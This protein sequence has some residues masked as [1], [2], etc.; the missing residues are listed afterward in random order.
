LDV[1]SPQPVLD[2]IVGSIIGKFGQIDVLVNN[3]G[4]VASGVWEEMSHEET[5]AQFNTNFFGA[6]NLTRAVLPTMRAQKSGTLVF[7]SSIAAWHGVGAGGPYSSSKFALEGAVECLEKETS[8]LGIETFL[9][10]LGQF[11]TDILN[12]ARK[13]NKKDNPI[14]DYDRVSAEL[15]DRHQETTGK[16]PGDPKLA[17]ERIL[18]V[19]RREGQLKGFTK[20]PLRIP[21]GSDAVQVMQA[22]CEETMGILKQPMP[23]IWK[24]IILTLLTTTL[25]INKFVTM[26][27]TVP[28]DKQEIIT[29]LFINN[30]YVD[31]QNPKKISVY[32]PTTEELV[33]DQIPV[34]G[35]RDVDAAVAAGNAA[36]VKWRA[37]PG[38]KRR[39]LLL[40]FADLLE[41]DQEELGFL[42]RLTLGAPYLAFGQGEIQT[43][44]ENF[45]YFAGWIDKFAGESFPQDDGFYK[46]VRNE[47]LGVVAGIIPWNGPLASVGLKA[48]PA[49]ATGNVFILK[50]SEKTP[51]MA[52][53]LGKLIIE[54]G[55][56]PGVF[57]VLS[58]DGSTGALLASHMNV[59]KVS[60]TGS[61][62][63][64][65]TVQILAAQSNLKRVTLELGGKSPAV[66][67]D[68][69]NLE[70]ATEWC[71]N[72]MTVNSGQIC[73]APSRVYCQ[74]GIY[75]RFLELY[76]KKFSG[77]KMGDPENKD[78][79]LGP[80]IDK[81]QYDRIVSMITTAE[82]EKQGT[83]LQG[84]RG[85]SGKGFFI[86]P[87]I[88]VDTK[89]NA[90]I[91][92]DEI[93]GPVVV[94]NR[95]ET[96]EEVVAKSNNSKYG[97]M[98]GVF[99]Q[100]INRAL[101]V[102]SAF[103]SGVVG[104]N[105]IST[106][107]IS[108][109]FGGTKESGIGREQGSAALRCYTEPKTVL[110]NLTY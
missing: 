2:N 18:D 104:I 16:Q 71:V 93:F 41:R 8:H 54:A 13:Q 34:A 10:V 78:T 49:L 11:R 110:I 84:G 90:T 27:L 62:Q 74:A 15:R 37:W 35:E 19:V 32:N 75:D 99:T 26:G 67:F 52:A 30:E 23:D 108:C 102:S 66:I 98:A 21:L 107:N 42:T 88:F 14:A 60:F 79:S 58:G 51:L 43:A 48:A 83:L 76:A 105:C 59:A 5:T 64:G 4:Y 6:L 33:S 39:Q 92:K 69:A 20:L 53:A 77:K 89:E 47:P 29:R 97:L 100:D 96:E 17:V 87:A 68:D 101:R 40:K 73:F 85:T 86:Q 61:V 56:P 38:A 3:A 55:F 36:F 7:M 82:S 50:P 46:I 44:V 31:C 109:P 103:D 9:M 70:N 95:F 72:T 81:A 63:T 45:R 65:K 57:Q 24:Q 25:Q 22:K 28:Q 91:Y 1:T 80:V 106:I 12:A 94:I